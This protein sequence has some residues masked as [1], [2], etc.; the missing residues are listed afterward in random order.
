MNRRGD[1]LPVLGL[2]LQRCK[3]GGNCLK[4][5]IFVQFTQCTKRISVFYNAMFETRTLL[6][7]LAGVPSN[8]LSDD[9]EKQLLDFQKECC[10]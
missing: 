3:D 2:C 10:G 4:L 8:Y 7:H 6:G 9:G 1:F 5:F